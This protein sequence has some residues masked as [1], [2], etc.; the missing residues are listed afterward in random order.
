MA[1]HVGDEV[2]VGATV[3]VVDTKTQVC[4]SLYMRVSVSV[5]RC[6][7][8]AVSAFCLSKWLLNVVT[9]CARPSLLPLLC[10]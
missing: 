7:W 9:V 6:R 8:E 10:P 3:P 1:R 2:D 5:E 4:D